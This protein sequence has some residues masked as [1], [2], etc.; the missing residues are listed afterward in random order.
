MREKNM[1]Q[2][3][4]VVT[5][6]LVHS[7]QI[8]ARSKV[9]ETLKTAIRDINQKFVKLIAAPF[10]IVWGDSFQG[11]LKSL[12]GLYT[13]LESF[14]KHLLVNFRCGLGIGQI[15]TRF[16]KNALEMDG[17]AFHRSKEALSVAEKKRRSI[18]IQS[19]KEPFDRMVNTLFA[20]LSTIKSGWTSRQRSIIQ[21][22]RQNLTYEG[23]GKKENITKQAVSNILKSAHW[24]VASLAIETLNNLS[25]SEF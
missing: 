15:S 9:Q 21:L 1:V 23:I 14:E 11:V 19:N 3:F 18:W 22:R 7:K 5:C 24:D 25:F 4:Y 16:S 2:I 6:D 12:E 13:I 10:V 17:P 20:L 8:K